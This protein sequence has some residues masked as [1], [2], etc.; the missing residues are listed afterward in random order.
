MKLSQI[1][2][3]TLRI[4]SHIITCTLIEFPYLLAFVFFSKYHELDQS[5]TDKP[6]IIYILLLLVNAF[7]LYIYFTKNV[8]TKSKKSLEIQN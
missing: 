5:Y 1:L 3:S 2:N 6:E 7:Q 4:Q 8:F